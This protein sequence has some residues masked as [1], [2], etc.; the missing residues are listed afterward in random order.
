VAAFAK[1]VEKESRL[2]FLICNAGIMAL[3]TRELTQ[4]GFEKQIG[5]NHFGHAYLISLLKPKLLAQSHPSR[6]VLLSSLA[7]K[8]GTIICENLHF[9][10][11]KKRPYKPW[12][13][14]GQSKLANLLWAKTLADEFKG[15]QVLAA[16][17][18]PGVIQTNLVRH[19]SALQWPILGTLSTWL[20]SMLVCDKNIPQGAATTIYAAL[21]PD[22]EEIRGAYL[23]DCAIVVPTEEGQDATG[24]NRAA[25]KKQTDLELSAALA[26]S[27]L[28]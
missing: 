3:E 19:I 20:F 8:M 18:H 28:L 26:K 6:I 1:E 13:A 25:L 12:D 2:D 27:N 16:S 14:Y 5:T 15:T 24:A 4:H 21:A 23:A 7:H 9:D 22:T 17:V 10:P 11:A